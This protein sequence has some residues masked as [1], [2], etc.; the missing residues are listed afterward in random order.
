MQD[1]MKKFENITGYGQ[2][3]LKGNFYSAVCVFFFLH[4][5]KYHIL[6]YDKTEISIQCSHSV[7]RSFRI[8]TGM[9]FISF[10]FMF[11]AF[12]DSTTNFSISYK[13]VQQNK[14]EN[15]GKSHSRYSQQS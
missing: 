10:F 12:F 8:Y 4:L 3:M 14:T 9:Q 11:L 6:L 5:F 1:Y 13:T 7:G 15:P 2:Q